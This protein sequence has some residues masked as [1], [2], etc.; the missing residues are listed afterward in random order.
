LSSDKIVTSIATGVTDFV[1]K[2]MPSSQKGPC[3]DFL[4]IYAKPSLQLTLSEWTPTQ[5]CD[6]MHVCKSSTEQQRAQI[7]KN[8][9]PAEKGKVS[10]DACK[11]LSKTLV[12]ELQQPKLQQDIVSALTQVCMQLPLG[13]YE[14]KCGDLAVQYIPF[15]MGWVADFF[16][17]SDACSILHMC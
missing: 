9:S 14:N 16:A 2:L 7:F 15:A 11:V 13:K 12:Y 5:I 17:R 4:G 3:S 10:C 1:C 6:A 8:L